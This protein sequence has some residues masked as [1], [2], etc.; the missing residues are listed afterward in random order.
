MLPPV[1]VTSSGILPLKGGT[2]NA[3]AASWRMG[4]I[5]PR[6]RTEGYRDAR[7]KAAWIPLSWGG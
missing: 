3:K 6:G 1:S 5:E 2:A 4:P 7:A